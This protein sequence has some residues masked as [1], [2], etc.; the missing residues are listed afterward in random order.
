[1]E[2]TREDPPAED[3]SPKSPPRVVNSSHDPSSVSPGSRWQLGPHPLRRKKNSWSALLCTTP[4]R[5]EN[6]CFG[7]TKTLSEED[8]RIIHRRNTSAEVTDWRR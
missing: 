2:N 4:P 1:M 3:Q 6:D 7:K 8:P 5:G